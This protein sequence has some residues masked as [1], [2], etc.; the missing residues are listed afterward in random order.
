MV[1]CTK[2]LALNRKWINDYFDLAKKLL[3]YTILKSNDPG[4][5]MSITKRNRIPIII[6]QRYVLSP[7]Y[8]GKEIGLI[9]PLEYEEEEYKKDGVVEID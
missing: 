4:V 6:N 5:V 3:E 8:N 7:E 1:Q 2:K 9:M